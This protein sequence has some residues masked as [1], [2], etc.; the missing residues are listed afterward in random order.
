MILDIVKK[1]NY[2]LKLTIGR[3]IIILSLF[4]SLIIVVF[5]LA[6]LAAFLPLLS[7]LTNPQNHY[8][9]EKNFIPSF[10][11]V[12]TSKV[13]FGLIFLIT[14]FMIKNLMTYVATRVIY[15]IQIKFLNNL[16]IKIV[17]LYLNQD[18]TFFLEN[19]SSKLV[20]VCGHH[21]KAIK[22]IIDSLTLLFIE[23]LIN[24][25]ILI[26][27][28]IFIGKPA[29]LLFSLFLLF[30][31]FYIFFI[32]K[33]FISLGKE[34]QIRQF[35]IAKILTEIFNSVKELYAYNK[36]DVF[37]KIFNFN[38]EKLN[39]NELKQ[40]NFNFLPKFF[41]ESIIVFGFSLII[42]FYYISYNNLLGLNLLLG[43]FGIATLRFVPGTNKII[44]L[45]QKIV[46]TRDSLNLV[47]FNFINLK[48][49]KN[50]Q[51]DNSRSEIIFKEIFFDNISFKYNSSQNYILKKIN[52]KIA[53]G[54][55]VGICGKSGSGKTTFIDIFLGLLKPSE[56]N[57]MINNI[58]SYSLQ[59]FWK[60]SVGYIPQSPYMFDD[61]V[62][63]NITFFEDEKKID[64]KK[65]EKVL[66]LSQ[67]NSF[68][69]NLPQGIRTIIGEKGARI[70]GGQ[71]QRIVIARVLYQNPQIL[72]FDEATNALDSKTEIEILNS[73]KELNANYKVTI[74]FITHKLDLIKNFKYIYKVE[75]GSL[76]NYN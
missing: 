61:S 55:L 17:N 32:K 19:N 12:L 26:A 57:I 62:L 47:Y 10:F 72:I 25:I 4:L 58:N 11:Y 35:K 21:A 53:Q 2:L 43:V 42:Y 76:L 49:P 24:I 73:I 70:S 66:N 75:N 68:V 8:M 64:E 13:E 39:G 51:I 38:I 29:I 41:I 54:D 9:L 48:P 31:F 23:I 46:V 56:G 71:K 27:L 33:I 5:E 40:S 3:K 50:L 30:I 7:L 74:I 37:V 20:N 44:L 1:I 34:L 36:K 28:I 69:E 6:G 14:V 65:L 63:N 52:L 59:D 22:N 67:L 18:Y 60:G 45:Y 15:K 16:S